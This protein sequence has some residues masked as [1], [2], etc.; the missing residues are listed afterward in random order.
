[1]KLK[2]AFVHNYGNGAIGFDIYLKRKIIIYGF[3]MPYLLPYVVGQRK[4][5]GGERVL[6][7]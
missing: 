2:E 6:K 4:W 1:M 3:L 7:F 5:S